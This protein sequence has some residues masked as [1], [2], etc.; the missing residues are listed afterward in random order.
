MTHSLLPLLLPAVDAQIHFVAAPDTP[1]TAIGMP[2][3]DEEPRPPLLTVVIVCT[4]AGN[5]VISIYC[6]G[7]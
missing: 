5:T 4:G 7:R 3:P 1:G 6:I 2:E